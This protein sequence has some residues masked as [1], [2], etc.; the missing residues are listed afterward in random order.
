MVSQQQQAW[1]ALLQLMACLT[2]G[3]VLSTT[4]TIQNYCLPSSLSAQ[5]L[6]SDDAQC[7]R[8][9]T[10]SR[11]YSMY[12]TSDIVVPPVF[13]VLTSRTSHAGLLNH[14]LMSVLMSVIIMTAYLS[15]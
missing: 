11:V 13:S 14:L 5:L 12:N 2:L 10:I 15:S 8:V 7:Q 9:A 3:P 1:N 6:L 4:S